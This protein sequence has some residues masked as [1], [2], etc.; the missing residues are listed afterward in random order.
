MQID[1]N[2]PAPNVRRDRIARTCRAIHRYLEIEATRADAAK[3]NIR[4]R[5]AIGLPPIPRR[6]NRERRQ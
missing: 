2:S 5:M 4:L 6:I 1:Q 3:R